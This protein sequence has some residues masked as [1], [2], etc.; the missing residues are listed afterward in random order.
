MTYLPASMSELVAGMNSSFVPDH[1][2][3]DEDGAPITRGT[4]RLSCSRWRRKEPTTNYRIRGTA[5]LLLLGVGVRF[6]GIGLWV[7]AI[8]GVVGV[9]FPDRVALKNDPPPSAASFRDNHARNV[10]AKKAWGAITHAFPDAAECEI[11]ITHH[12]ERT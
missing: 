7:S 11:G 2:V 4:Y 10:F 6:H 5:D 3:D 12:R 8:D 9:K 1:D